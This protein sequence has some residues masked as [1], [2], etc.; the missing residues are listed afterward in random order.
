MC[1]VLLCLIMLFNAARHAIDVGAAYA[2]LCSDDEGALPRNAIARCG[3]LHMTHLSDRVRWLQF[4][5]DGERLWAAGGA[6]VDC[7][8][9]ASGDLVG[10]MRLEHSRLPSI[11]SFSVS[12]SGDKVAAA[13]FSDKGGNVRVLSR[14]LRR[15]LLDFPAGPFAAIA[16]DSA[17]G[18]VVVGIPRMS[19]SK[20]RTDL[21]YIDETNGDPRRHIVDVDGLIGDLEVLPNRQC[22]LSLTGKVAMIDARSGEFVFQQ[23]TSHDTVQR[24]RISPDGR[25]L[26]VLSDDEGRL[27]S[28]LEVWDVQSHALLG[29]LHGNGRMVKDFVFGPDKDHVM[30]VFSDRVN[31]S[32]ICTFGIHDLSGAV[33]GQWDVP[34]P[35]VDCLAISA[36]N[37]RLAGAARNRLYVWDAAIG[38]QLSRDVPRLDSVTSIC[39]AP[40]G[41]LVYIGGI[42]G[43]V[44]VCSAKDGAFRAML[45]D[46]RPYARHNA[47]VLALALSADEHF[48]AVAAPFKEEIAVQLWDVG[49]EECKYIVKV[50]HQG[51]P[52]IA[53][54]SDDRMLLL[55]DDCEMCVWR[56]ETGDVI[57]RTKYSSPVFLLDGDRLALT[58]TSR[59]GQRELVIQSVADDLPI[60]TIPYKAI[61]ARIMIGQDGSDRVFV[62]DAD[63]R[64]SICSIVEGEVR[65]LDIDGNSNDMA[66]D[67]SGARI[68]VPGWYAGVEIVDVA[69]AGS[70]VALS[71]HYGRIT[72]IAF[73]GT[74][75]FTGGQDGTVLI[76]DTTRM[77]AP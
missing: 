18:D 5:D 53:F 77:Q 8:S 33:A 25:F 22:I 12:D 15:T 11:T 41:E 30:A 40:K 74:R 39:V 43:L 1:E 59:D 19:A 65:Q 4:S 3:S 27:R 2:C 36:D 68:A 24:I 16:I 49:K 32:N 26:A 29:A 35:A 67:Q 21:C 50:P 70:S 62:V 72:A 20:W 6:A 46:G 45:G 51:A 44:R 48:L 13:S 76:W 31:P 23:R 55:T 9:A 17:G 10:S 56:S 47:A 75:L 42:D 64:I 61:P 37:A 14:D 54:S 58:R 52:R 71:G 34:D 60:G 69:H 57:R 73:S 28:C 66:I 38:T 7:W 63:H